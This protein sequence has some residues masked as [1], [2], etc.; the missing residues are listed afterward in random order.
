MLSESLRNST[1]AVPAGLGPT[2]RPWSGGLTSPGP[3]KVGELAAELM[4]DVR[5]PKRRL[6]RWALRLC[7]GGVG[8][9]RLPAVVGRCECAERDGA[10]LV[11]GHGAACRP[12]R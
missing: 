6:V 3:P 12:R 11:Q 7:R 10:R 5:Q 9:A 8:H 1:I 2:A 4:A